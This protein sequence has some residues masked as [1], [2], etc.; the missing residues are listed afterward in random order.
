[1]VASSAHAPA[2]DKNGD[3]I[4]DHEKLATVWKQFLENKFKATDREHKRDEYTELGPQ[5]VADPLT[6]EAFVRAL[7]KLKKGKA[8]GPDGI[9]GEVF[10]NCETA[11]LELYDLLKL[12][13][14]REYVPPTLVRAAFVMLYK[15]KGSINDTT[16]YRCLALLPHAYKVL[17]L[18]MLERIMNECSDFLSDWQAGFRPER[19][20]RDNI[21]LLRMLYDQVIANDDKLFV[22]WLIHRLFGGVRHGESQVP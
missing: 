13:W 6:E 1:M 5:L 16:K 10:T 14:E 15:N 17:S 4:L 18:V 2:V 20:C 9:P 3:L 7:K 19:G 11:A 21:L 12:I 8:C 22:T